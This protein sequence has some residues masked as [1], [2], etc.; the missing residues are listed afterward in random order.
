MNNF[1]TIGLKAL[2]PIFSDFLLICGD[3]GTS[4]PDNCL[5]NYNHLINYS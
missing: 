2:S 4:V 5:T 1:S 3:E